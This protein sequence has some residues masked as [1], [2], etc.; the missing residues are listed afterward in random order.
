MSTKEKAEEL[1]NQYFNLLD[2]QDNY[3]GVE[4]Q[5]KTCAKIAVNEIISSWKLDGNLRNDKSII[6]WW[7]KV[8]KDID[9]L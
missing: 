1:Y 7:E 5:C 4:E 2:H 3:C 9:T 6:V 8:L